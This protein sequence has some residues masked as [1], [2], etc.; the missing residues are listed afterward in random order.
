MP[1]LI[2]T[3]VLLRSMQPSHPMYQSAVNAMQTLL[4]RDRLFVAVQNVAELW[5]VMTRPVQTNGLGLSIA[6]AKAELAKI[7]MIFTI[8]YETPVSYG[9][10]KILLTSH[11][12]IGVQVHDTRLVS[13]DAGPWCH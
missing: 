8:L 10:L 4:K 6:E 3:N 5:N 2:D 13:G 9:A 7:D 1:A 12:V 11:N